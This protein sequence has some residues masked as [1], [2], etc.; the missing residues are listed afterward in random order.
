MAQGYLRVPILQTTYI[1][2]GALFLN[3]KVTAPLTLRPSQ[4]ATRCYRDKTMY[5]CVKYGF[6]ISF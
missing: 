3:L 5:V 6:H 2:V 1:T 4:S